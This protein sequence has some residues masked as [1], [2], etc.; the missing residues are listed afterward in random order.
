M[1]TYRRRRVAVT[2]LGAVSPVGNT[3]PEFWE[4]LVAGTSGVA[5]IQKFDTSRV[6]VSIGAEVKG[7]DPLDYADARTVRRND[8]TAIYQLAAAREAMADAGLTEVPCPSAFGVVIGLDV[9]YQ[10]IV[11]ASHGLERLG[12]LGVDVYALLQA[13]P[14]TAPALVAHTFGLRGATN[15]VAASCA[16]GAVALLQAWNMIQL[17]YVEAVLA[18]CVSALDEGLVATSASARVLS[19]ST[20]PPAASRPFDLGRDGF[21]LGEGAAAFILEAEEHARERGTRIHAEFLGGSQTASIAGFTI[22]PAEDCAGCMASALRA[23]G[24]DPSEIDVVGAHATST[25]LGDKQ[26]AEALR[27]IFGARAVPA[28]AA[29]SVLGHCMSASAGL[30]TAAVLLAMRDGIAPPTINHV[31]PDPDCDVDCVPNEARRLPIRVALK[32][33]FGF[34]GVNC[35]LVFRAWDD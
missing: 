22:N 18:G 12:Q 15:A 5:R 16:S 29:K 26:E 23:T 11:R 28:F 10:S 25:I 9:A 24:T 32:N 21:V 6:D 20:D 7:F 19:K 8:P 2:G 30:E 27:R 34:G 31:H 13:L 3:V 14:G 1:S 4:A 33:S 35:C 17:G